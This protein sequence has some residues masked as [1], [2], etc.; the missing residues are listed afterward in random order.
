MIILDTKGTS[1]K[2]KTDDEM[3]DGRAGELESTR[4]ERK[5]RPLCSPMGRKERFKMP[6]KKIAKKEMRGRGGYEMDSPRGKEGD[7]E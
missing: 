2:K 3:E 4:S 6:G 5:R 7:D 1:R